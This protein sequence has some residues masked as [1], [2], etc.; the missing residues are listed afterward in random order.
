MFEVSVVKSV[1]L[2]IIGSLSFW[3]EVRWAPF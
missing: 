2:N 3:F 1:N